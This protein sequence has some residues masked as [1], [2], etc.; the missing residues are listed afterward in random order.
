MEK[1]DEK[2]AHD[3]SGQPNSIRASQPA[4][5]EYDISTPEG[6][7]NEKS[8]RS[9]REWAEGS[10]ESRQVNGEEVG[11]GSDAEPQSY[12]TAPRAVS[13]ASSARSRALSVVP[14][15]RRRGLFARLAVIVPEVY[16]PFDYS[17]KTKWAITCIVALAAS[18]APMGSG[19]LYPVLTDVSVDL[20]TSPTIANL[21]IAVYTLAMAIFPIWWS[22]FSETFG[23]RTIYIVSFGLGIVFSILS[24]VS[25]NIAM[26]IV[27]RV[28]GG[29]ASASVQA[30]GAGTIADIWEV[31]ERGKAMGMFYLGPLMGPLLAPIVGGALA[32]K[33]NWR[34]TMWFVTIHAGLVFLM[35]LFCLP[36]TLRRKESEQL[37]RTVERNATDDQPQ[38]SRSAT[39]QSI[40]KSTKDSVKT[41]KRYVIDPLKVLGT[42]RFLPIAVT[43]FIA[44]ITFGSLFVLNISVQSAYSKSP[45]GFSTLIVGL[46]YIPSSLGYVISSIFGGRWIDYIMTREARKAERYD[47]DGKLIYLPED[48]MC[49]NAWLAAALYPSALIMFGWT[50]DKGLYWAVPSVASLL[51]GLSSMLIFSA[52]TTMLTEFMP[53]RSSSGIAVNN[54]VRNIFS[55]IGTV[56]AQPLINAMGVGWLCT[57]VGLLALILSLGSVYTLKRFGSKWRK[58]MDLKLVK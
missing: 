57:M 14:T 5:A 27:M 4:N 55:C 25:T 26:L 58:E 39:R 19:I 21:T 29:G 12:A 47:A 37:P 49:E 16:R 23:R 33:W 53:S 24:A 20:K 48:R 8:H 34:S 43:V 40:A 9:S 2:A 18:A 45:Y 50:I 54:F 31:R 6:S 22:S 44:A 36:E 15:S 3:S 11:E 51:F 38:L 1:S 17:N 10:S 46:L 52:A 30:V 32:L 56:I 7:V 35:L 42:L 13:R 28:L 41:V